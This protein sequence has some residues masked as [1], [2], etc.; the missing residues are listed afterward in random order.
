MKRLTIA[1]QMTPQE[2]RK[3]MLSLSD[4]EVKQFGYPNA[5][6][7]RLSY[8][9]SEIAGQWRATKDDALVH[10]YTSVLYEMILKGYDVDTLPIQDQLPSD[11]MPE[12]PPKS[13]QLAIQNAY[14]VG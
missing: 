14:R 5:K 3:Y 13:V 9:L 1:D 7:L 12:I 2:H 8:R 4:E 6:V 10:E 11:L